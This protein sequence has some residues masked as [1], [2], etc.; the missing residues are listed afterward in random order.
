LHLS[1]NNT[2]AVTFTLE[3]DKNGNGQWTKLRDV[4]VPAKGYVWTEFAPTEG[5][6]WLRIVPSADCAKTTAFFHYRNADKRPT[7]NAA[8]FEG[9]AQ[10]GSQNVNGGLLSVR[11]ADFKTLRVVTTKDAVYDLDGELKLNQAD[12]PAGLTWTK[13]N[14]AI[15]EN[16]L[17]VDA[18]SVLY[19]DGKNRWRLPK[20][21]AA[22]DTPGALGLERIDREVCTER[23]LFNAHGT[24]YELPAENAGGF[25]KI[26]PIATHNRR[27]KDYASY[28]GM[29]LL[30]GLENGAKG[31][32]IIP[33]ADGQC[34][35][36]AGVVDDLWKLGKPRGVGGP[37][38]DS[39]VKANVPS[40][41]YLMTAYDKKRV[42]L[43]HSA[44][45]PVKIR[46]EVDL[47]GSGDWV[48]Y[49]EFEIAPGQ[50]WEHTFPQSFSAYWVRAVAD[51]DTTA[52]AIF[53]YE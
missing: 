18:A 22:F 13:T 10:P 35:L 39:P 38:K 30:S 19:D 8:L 5:G 49:N 15:P 1:H 44:T 46:L 52:S 7:E 29:L 37:W 45:T 42:T 2:Q 32:R 25:A 23:D 31:E 43:S 11:G 20:G 40:D 50:K 33:S 26:R 16:V 17:S 6:V 53:V 51:K 21:D 9:L 41:P 48:N 12:D 4:N 3:V 34:A 24:F 28:R 14:F 36:W 47:T 27:I